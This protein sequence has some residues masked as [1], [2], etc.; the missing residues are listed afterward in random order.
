MTH[1]AN[2]S[3]ELSF[4]SD[5]DVRSSSVHGGW[6]LRGLLVAS[7]S[8]AQCRLALRMSY[9]SLSWV[10]AGMA[11]SSDTD[12]LL[13]MR[14]NP[15]PPSPGSMSEQLAAFKNGLGIWKTAFNNADRGSVQS[16]AAR[17]VTR[18]VLENRMRLQI[19]KRDENIW[20]RSPAAS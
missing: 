16:H 3:A 17:D 9:Q 15:T 4:Q 7:P 6:V 13:L 19:L 8:M 1:L 5:L 11:M 18:S 2:T 14:W 10:K 20:R 12:E